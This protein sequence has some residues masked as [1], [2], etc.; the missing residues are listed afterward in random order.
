MESNILEMLE[1]TCKK[2]PNKVAFG[3]EQE[4]I[5]FSK[6]IFNA[7]T[8]GS[9]LS[10]K[11][12]INTPIIICLE[13]NIKSILGIFGVIY[14][15]GV[16]SILDT[17]LPKNR[18]EKIIETLDCNIILTDSLNYE[19]IKKVDFKGEIINI[20][21]IL[22]YSIDEEKLK[23]VKERKLD[24][25]PL[26]INFTSGST[27]SPKGVAISHKSV[28]EFIQHFVEIFKINENDIIG[29]QAPLDFDVSVKDIYSGIFTG[30]KV[31][32]IPRAYFSN[33]KKLMDYL[34]EKE[35]T[36]LIWA[37]SAMCFL[38]I[39]NGFEY[40]VPKKITKIMFS[41]EIMPIK[42]LKI[43]KKYIPKALYVNLY[44]PTEIT[45]NC[46]YYILNEEDSYDDK[47]ILPIGIPFPNEKVFLLNE[48]NKKIEKEEEIGEICVSGTSVAL[49][50]YNDLEKTKKVFVQ[51]P[52][53]KKY[54]EIIYR[55]GDLGKYDCEGNLYYVTRK[56]FQIKHMGHRIELSEIE[57]LATT[58]EK[59]SQTCCI[60]DEV[61]K[62]IHMFYIGK[63]EKKELLKELKNI[64]PVYMIPN[65]IIQLENMPI[66]KNGKID[67]KVLK[68]SEELKSER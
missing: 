41:G 16:Y 19:I 57:V 1:K 17:K 29:N 33:P 49:G 5:T 28:L 14:A 43:W 48:E 23:R 3:D 55:T 37:V 42:Q 68:E 67:R 63:K 30:A 44:G 6:L 52:L 18:M 45:C 22:S 58:I 9:F 62:R 4:D 53:N 40:K 56:D 8:I 25:D 12:E 46:T 38:S 54:P 39:M 50:Y 31:Q 35:I 20:E 64:L 34:V 27:G 61:K 47:T 24:I 65:K 66:N 59:V 10:E 32:L 21:K 51:N 2:Y 13:K 11:I 26:Y 15:G 36:T 7:K 60:Y